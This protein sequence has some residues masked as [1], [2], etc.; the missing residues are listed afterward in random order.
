MTTEDHKLRRKLEKAEGLYQPLALDRDEVNRV[1]T[2][3]GN[4]LDYEKSLAKKGGKQ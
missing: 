4:W 3:V 1:A 2:M